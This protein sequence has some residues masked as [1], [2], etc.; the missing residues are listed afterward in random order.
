M[1]RLITIDPAAPEPAALAAATEALRAGALIAFP[2]DTV[3]A[4]ACD[5]TNAAAAR[6]I[7]AAKGRPPDQPLI[8]LGHDA[9]ALFAYGRP[10]PA[11]EALAARFWPGPLTLVVP[12][13]ADLPTEVTAGGGTIGLR[14]P[15]H[16]VALKLL[17]SYGA[18]LATTSANRSGR[19]EAVTARQVAR[20]LGDAVDIV[21]AGGPRPAGVV[22]TVLDLTREPAT[23]V[24]RGAVSIEQIGEVIGHVVVAGR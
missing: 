22:S 11:A 23:I 3:Y 2:T 16:P 9:A 20:A 6:R 14:V 7:F 8:L 21:V 15:D 19:P 13:A 10:S 24:R 4:V 12:L 5:P 17:E 18:P 1:P